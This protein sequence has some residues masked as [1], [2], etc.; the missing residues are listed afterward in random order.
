MATKRV[1][2]QFEMPPENADRMQELAKQADVTKKEII[3]GA[4]AILEWTVGEV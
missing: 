4:L 2:V 3:N 1:K